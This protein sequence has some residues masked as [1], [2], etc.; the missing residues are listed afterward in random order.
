M[1]SLIKSIFFDNPINEEHVIIVKR[2]DKMLSIIYNNN[3]DGADVDEIFG[4][5]RKEDFPDFLRI[6]H[7][8]SHDPEINA[9]QYLIKNNYVYLDK[10]QRKYY[11]TYEGILKIKAHTFESDYKNEAIKNHLL[12]QHQNNSILKNNVSIVLSVLAM[13]ITIFKCN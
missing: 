6:I 12:I 7:I 2:L 4:N 1:F 3:N 13:L 5:K 9:L 10:E 11:C 8:N